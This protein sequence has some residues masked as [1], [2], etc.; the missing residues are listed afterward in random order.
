MLRKLPIHRTLENHKGTPSGEFMQ[1]RKMSEFWEN[2]RWR[3]NPCT[4]PGLE[5]SF[6][7]ADQSRRTSALPCFGQ[8][9]EKGRN[10]KAEKTLLWR[11]QPSDHMLERSKWFPRHCNKA[12]WSRHP[13]IFIIQQSQFIV[14]SILSK[15]I[16]RLKKKAYVTH[17]RGKRHG[18][19]GV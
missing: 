2:T 13:G 16:Q 18:R 11:L 8:H 19:N 12:W 7:S 9:D 6:V 14:T 15:L 4:P 17:I 3:N 1:A 5:I 10:S